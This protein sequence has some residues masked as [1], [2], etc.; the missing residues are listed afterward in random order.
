MRRHFSAC[1]LF[2]SFAPRERE[3][4]RERRDLS[5]SLFSFLACIAQRRQQRERRPKAAIA[6][7]T[8]VR[9]RAL[10]T[11]CR[12]AHCDARTRSERIERSDAREPAATG[13]AA[14]APGLPGPSISTPLS[15]GRLPAFFGPF[16][17]SPKG[18]GRARRERSG[19]ESSPTKA[20]GGKLTYSPVRCLAIKWSDLA[21]LAA[22]RPVRR[23]VD[24]CESKLPQ[25]QLIN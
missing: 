25:T 12:A 5:Q 14:P 9:A 3:R 10:P 17:A 11:G 22:P 4:G 24:P 20:N 23:S 19:E 21:T 7:S 8:D 6:N 1:Y 18:G 16:E 2:I 15:S 13:G